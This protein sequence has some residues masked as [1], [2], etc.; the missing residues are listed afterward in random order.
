MLATLDVKLVQL[1]RQ[2]AEDK[3][4]KEAYDKVY[5]V[6]LSEVQ[7]KAREVKPVVRPQN[8]QKSGPTAAGLAL[9]QKQKEKEREAER[10]KEREI[11]EIAMDV[12][13]TG[14]SKGKSRRCAPQVVDNRR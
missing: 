9:M 1:S 2:T 4:A 11:E 7:E 14:D 10:A 13:D 6:T 5:Q 12:D 3:T 8:L